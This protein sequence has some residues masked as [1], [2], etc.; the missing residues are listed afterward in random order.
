MSALLGEKPG[1]RVLSADDEAKRLMVEKEELR[2]ALAARFG[3]DI[4]R[5]DGSLNRAGLAA[6]VFGDSKELEALNAIVHPA[7]R[8]ELGESI[9]QAE[10]DDIDLFVYEAA[11]FYEIGVQN[12]VDAV[13]LVDAPAEARI[14]RVMKRDGSTRSEVLA[15]MTNQLAP[16]DVRAQADFVVDNDGDLATL[17]DSVD[18]LYDSLLG[19]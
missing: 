16:D 19:K 9:R 1:V 14:H 18:A 15:R 3:S 4:Y 5:S 7:V 13:L 8:E 6:R 12:L 11:L 17:H 2:N 10:D